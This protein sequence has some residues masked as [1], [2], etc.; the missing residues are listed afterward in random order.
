VA[1]CIETVRPYTTKSGKPMGFVTIEDIQGVIELVLFTKTWEK[2]RPTLEQGKIIL[3]EG[4]VDATN[5]PPKI[6]VDN[7]RTE[8]AL[9][10]PADTTDT[11]PAPR[12]PRPASN[13]PKPKAASVKPAVHVAEAKPA[14]PAVR[15]VAPST[16]PRTGNLSNTEDDDMPPP[17]ENFPAGWD[18]EWQPSF[19][20]AVIAERPEPKR[21]KVEPP[22]TPPQ[23][24]EPAALPVDEFPF[25][26]TEA[27]P[28]AAVAQIADLRSVP[29]ALPSLYI[30]LAETEDREHPLQQITI[31]LRPTGDAA[32]DKR[33]IKTIYGTLISFHGRDRFTFQI[34]ENGKGHLID[35]PNDTTRI[36]PEL[37]VRLKK[38]VGEESWRI[39][40]IV[41]Q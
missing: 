41:L 3:V 18:S 21:A 30:P 32:V 33:R 22:I 31:I 38:V 39:E 28:A 24:L 20:N 12:L 19:E 26:E 14:Y 25:E 15:Q 34:F 7:I 37:L 40:P 2:F 35:F 5:T 9:T 17:P 11:P 27:P 1:G 8:I 4:R 13:A 29:P 6:L 10:T 23:T 36:C 16:S